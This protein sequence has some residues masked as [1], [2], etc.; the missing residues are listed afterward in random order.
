MME[1]MNPVAMCKVL[2]K[3]SC[4]EIL[5]EGKWN[6]TVAKDYVRPPQS[7]GKGSRNPLCELAECG[8]VNCLAPR[9]VGRQLR[10]AEDC[11]LKT[12]SFTPLSVFCK[13][14]VFPQG[15]RMLKMGAKM[16]YTACAFAK[17]HC[18]ASGLEAKLCEKTS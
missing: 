12:A 11:R 4:F 3:N 7:L 18:I 13:N 14:D 16:R 5:Q 15:L 9:I 17:V 1:E 8:D 10:M 6:L 2:A